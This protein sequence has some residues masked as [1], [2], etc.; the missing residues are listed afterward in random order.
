MM[1]AFAPVFADTETCDIWNAYFAD[2]DRLV[3]LIGP[4]AAELSDDL[5]AHLTDSFA[6]EEGPGGEAERLQRAIDRL[7]R[8]ADFLRPMLADELI[9]RGTAKGSILLISRGLYHAV[10]SGSGRALRAA[11]FALG[12]VLLGIFAVMTVLKPF[13]GNHIGLIRG[14][15]GSLT[16]GMVSQD[17]GQELLGLWSV[18][19]TL[20]LCGLLYMLL[21]RMLRR[22]VRTV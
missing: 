17:G 20:A 16:F 21:T 12:Y 8:P 11:V 5:R 1:P 3:R 14:A 9:D 4:G 15:D 19:L 2:V 13:F 22:T 7:G 6:S 18:P 10:R